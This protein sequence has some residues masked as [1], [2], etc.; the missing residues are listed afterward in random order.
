MK[1]RDLMHVNQVLCLIVNNYNV[2]YICDDF[3]FEFYQDE[4]GGDVFNIV[5][6]ITPKTCNIE[7]HFNLDSD[8]FINYINFAQSFYKRI[9]DEHITM[10]A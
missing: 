3:Y 7:S 8:E 5:S 6:E 4:K 1:K 10:E 9:K 2:K